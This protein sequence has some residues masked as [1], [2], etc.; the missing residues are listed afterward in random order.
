MCGR[1]RGLGWRGIRQRRL[2]AGAVLH[3]VRTTQKNEALHI[4]SLKFQEHS[5]A[6]ELDQVTV[7]NLELVEPLFQGQDSRATL[8]H[9]L[10]ACLTPMGKRLLRA[11][12]LRPLLDAGAIE[13]R[14]EAV[15]EAQGDLLRRE[16]VRRAFSGILDLE[17]LLARLSLDSAGP[18]DI[19]ALAASLSRLPGLK[20][21]VETMTA[22]EWCT[23]RGA[24][25][26]AGRR[27]AAD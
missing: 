16:E 8:F 18:R 23:P 13:A 5:T 6:L 11:T 14:Y 24:S 3:Y 2:Q 10:D 21:A 15:A 1:W 22:A 26:H 9:T 17:R 27:D 20:T 25:R 7:R 12:I 19:R 4:D